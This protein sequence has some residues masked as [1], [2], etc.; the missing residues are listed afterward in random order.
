M[1]LKRVSIQKKNLQNMGKK[2]APRY[3][4]T[5][6]FLRTLSHGPHYWLCSNVKVK[7]TDRGKLALWA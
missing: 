6:W 7:K 2:I 1:I 5:L 3:A 4:P